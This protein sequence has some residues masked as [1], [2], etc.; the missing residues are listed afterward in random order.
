VGLRGD[1]EALTVPASLPQTRPRWGA[2]RLQPDATWQVDEERVE[3]LR[4]WTVEHVAAAPSVLQ[5][6][7]RYNAEM[8]YLIRSLGVLHH[9]GEGHLDRVTRPLIALHQ[10][11]AGP[12]QGIAE[13][14][15]ARAARVGGGE[16]A[17]H[18][19]IPGPLLYWPVTAGGLGLMQPSVVIE[20]LPGDRAQREPRPTCLTE[21]SWA[22]LW[23]DIS[24][25]RRQPSADPRPW[26]VR[27]FIEQSS[28]WFQFLGAL[29]ETARLAEPA[30]SPLLDP[31]IDDFIQRGSEVGSRAQKTISPYW[32][33]VLHTYGPSLLD[34]VGT[35]R[36]LLTELV[37]LPLLLGDRASA[38]D[39]DGDSL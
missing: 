19:P 38:T 4:A 29:E 3:A 18:A 35:F 25:L 26:W 14:I 13:M 28:G 21:R 39:L 6:A 37:P 10:N 27:G 32:R 16:A 33:H 7:S 11:L 31:L 17:A 24:E 34:S 1:G 9:L 2:L 15:Q 5:M 20:A 12:G 36:F 8:S 23:Q 22:R 30:T